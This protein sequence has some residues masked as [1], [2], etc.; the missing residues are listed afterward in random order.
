MKGKVSRIAVNTGGGDAPGLNAV[1][2]ALTVAALRNG[3]EVTG[4]REGYG[5]LIDMP[6]GEGLVPLDRDSVR[7]ITHL[8]GTILDVVAGRVAT[9]ARARAPRLFGV[10]GAGARAGG[11]ACRGARRGLADG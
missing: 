5:G 10:S 6:P 4:I 1:I 11:T 2:R 9:L 7:G 3:W 8:G